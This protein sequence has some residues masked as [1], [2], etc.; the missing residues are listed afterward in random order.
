MLDLQEKG[1]EIVSRLQITDVIPQRLI[2]DYKSEIKGVTTF[3]GFRHR[4]TSGEAAKDYSRGQA[5]PVGV[6]A[7]PVSEAPNFFAAPCREANAERH[8]ASM[9]INS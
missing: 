4:Q 1:G 3:A 6:S 2:F 8:G 5:N 7:A 9:V